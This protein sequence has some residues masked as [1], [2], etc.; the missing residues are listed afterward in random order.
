MMWWYGNGIGGWGAALMIIGHVLFW[1]VIIIG[2]I[3]LI[4]YVARGDRAATT[5]GPRPTPE[6]LLAE[7]FARGEIEEQEYSSRLDTLT[8]KYRA[9]VEP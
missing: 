9:R 6:Q 7:R 8:H 5:A 4:R 2:V 1:A 3:A